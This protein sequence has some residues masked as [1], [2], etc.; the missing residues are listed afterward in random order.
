MGRNAEPVR[1]IGVTYDEWRYAAWIDWQC[2]VC[3]REI[4]IKDIQLRAPSHNDKAGNHCPMSHQ[5]LM[6]V[7]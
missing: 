1:G 6:A 3:W 7:T 5:T 2:P 4:P